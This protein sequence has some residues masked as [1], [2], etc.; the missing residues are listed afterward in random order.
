MILW[1]GS[2]FF[3]VKDLKF[4]Q[5][6]GEDSL[7]IQEWLFITVNIIWNKNLSLQSK[8]YV[9]QNYSMTWKITEEIKVQVVQFGQRTFRLFELIKSPK[10]MTKHKHYRPINAAAFEIVSPIT[11]Y[12]LG[13]INRGLA[14]WRYRHVDIETSWSVNLPNTHAHRSRKC[15]L[16]DWHISNREF[17]RRCDGDQSRWQSIRLT[18][19]SS[20]NT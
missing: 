8:I 19:S 16:I 6:R 20:S 4:D 5:R 15:S 11:R 18:A 2:W 13:G 9:Y 3:L 17:R 10:I 1:F 7:C 14:Q 12:T